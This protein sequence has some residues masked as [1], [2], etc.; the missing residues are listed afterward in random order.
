MT[1]LGVET[2]WVLSRAELACLALVTGHDRLLFLDGGLGLLHVSADLDA[3]R[4]SLEAV[5]ILAAAA[6]DVGRPTVVKD[7]PVVQALALLARAPARVDLTIDAN[8]EHRR[9][10]FVAVEGDRGV[11]VGPTAIGPRFSFMIATFPVVELVGRVLARV[12]MLEVATGAEVSDTPA[13]RLSISGAD[14]RR[15]LSLAET[16]SSQTTVQFLTSIGWSDHAAVE[17]VA[18]LVASPVAYRVS[19]IRHVGATL[20]IEELCWNTSSRGGWWVFE[21]ETDA[22]PV[23]FRRSNGPEIRRQVEE[24]VGAAK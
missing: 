17:I 18:D 2:S 23:L 10:H 7:H 14:L 21:N 9:V 8:D 22:G 16:E 24:I 20:T 11:E 3:A 19:G 15:V 5:G 13:T 1:V 6:G 4:V 12:Q